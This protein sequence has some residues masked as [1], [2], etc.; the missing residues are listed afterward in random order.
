MLSK[1]IAALAQQGWFDTTR[2]YDKTVYLTHGAA[3]TLLLSRNGKPVCFVKFSDRSSLALEA[4][5]CEAASRRFPGLAPSFIGY[6]CPGSLEILVTEGV[7][8]RALT[9]AMLVS[10]SHAR[11]VESGLEDYFRRM[12]EG[13]ADEDRRPHEWVEAYHRYFDSSPWRTAAHAGL[14]RL[15]DVLSPYPRLAQHGDFTL[16]N[17]GIADGGRL[18]VFDWEDYGAVDLPG[19]DL[20]TLEASLREALDEHGGGDLRRAGLDTA[21]DL[22]RMCDAVGLPRPLFEELRPSYAFVFRFL[23]RNYGPEIRNRV[24]LL[25]RRLGAA[26]APAAT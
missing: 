17:L 16:N 23:K 13:G 24:D 7:A 14:R 1:V 26:P 10:G 22:G 8:F 18:T 6:G 5:R 21:V 4:S 19:L 20:F 12:R 25:L 2:P 9:P 15:L 3:Q 11:A